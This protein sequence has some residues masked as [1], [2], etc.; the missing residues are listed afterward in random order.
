MDKYYYLISQLPTLFF[1]REAGMTLDA[2]FAEAR[3]WL[4]ARDLQRLQQVDMNDTGLARDP[5][6]LGNYKRFEDALRRDLA[7]W[8]RAR[9]GATEYSLPPHLN[10]IVKEGNPLDIE[11]KLLRLRWQFIEE[12][13]REHHFDLAFLILYVLKLQI[14]TRLS[15]F[16]EEKG[17]SAFKKICEVSL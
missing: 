2:F 16:D 5:G 4:T 14:L 15:I 3:K 17:L 12:M 1:D 8:R 13:E 11:K 10:A 9:A 7:G 6:V